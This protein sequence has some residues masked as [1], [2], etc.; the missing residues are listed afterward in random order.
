M[1]TTVQN[2]AVVDGSRRALIKTA[3]AGMTLGAIAATF[4]GVLSRESDAAT[5]SAGMNAMTILY[6]TG[7]GITFNADY[8]R[9]HH[10][11]TI[12]KLYGRSIRRFELRR[13][14][15]LPA[16]AAG[17]AGPPPPAYSAAVNIWIADLAAFNAHNA[18]H[19]AQLV[20]DMP[21]FTNAQ[22]TIQM[23][24]VHGEMGDKRGQM[25]VG[26]TCLTILY[27]NG[28][29]VRWDVDYYRTGHMPLIMNLYGREA[30]K[31]FEL[32]RGDSGQA[33]DSKAAFV[34]SVNIYINKQA[35]F[36][37]AG[38][39]HGPTLVKDVPNFSS[40]MPTAFPTAIHGV[41]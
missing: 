15:T 3:G 2:D 20:A 23:D 31:R 14:P 17:A 37:A 5:S 16:P 24:R 8:Y 4:G 18:K 19:G 26:D 7:L 36:D 28:D 21:N 40:V 38:Q 33:P 39:K 6:P 29:D 32:R 41:G 35:A 30:I 27:K 34:G 1:T 9:D 25:R 10:L 13:V 11:K 22:P 12:M